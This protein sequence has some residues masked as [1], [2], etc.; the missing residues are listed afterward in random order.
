MTATPEELILDFGVNP[1]SSG[2]PVQPI[3]IAQRVVSNL[4]T[5]KR[6]VQVLQMAI[7]QHEA[8]FGALE[9]DVRRRVRS[10]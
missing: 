8:A 7:H 3:V 9:T 10:E 6:L 1:Q 4:Y 5:A 2:V